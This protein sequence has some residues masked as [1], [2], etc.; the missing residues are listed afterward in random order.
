MSRLSKNIVYNVI[1][2][3]LSLILSFVAVRFIFR[4]LGGDALGLIYFNQS[5]SVAL[6]LALEL[7]IYK[8]TVREVASHYTAN[9]LYIRQLIGTATSFY[10]LA[11]V[12]L[13]T[14]S[15]FAVPA[16]IHHWVHLE[17]LDQITATRVMRILILGTLL[18]LPRG[19]Y[20]SLLLGLERMSYTNILRLGTV[21]VQQFG[22]FLVL[23][24]HGSL[25][26][27][28]Y[29]IVACWL[30]G[31]VTYFVACARL[32]SWRSLLP[33]FS[34]SVVKSNW[35]FSAHAFTISVSGWF[36]G[37]T[38]K[39]VIA[40][41]L[42]LGVMGTYTVAKGAV[43]RCS[44]L[45]VAINEATYPHLSALFKANDLDRFRAQY[46]KLQDLV[47]LAILPIYAAM[48]FVA[49][50]IF[51]FMFTPQV[52]R[53]LLLPVTIL[54]VG[55]YLYGTVT[56]LNVAALAAGK[57]DIMAKLNYFAVF[58]VVLGYIVFIRFFGLAGA[59]L[60]WALY[61]LL[62]FAYSVPRTCRECLG[63]SVGAWFA[64]MVK[65]FGLGGATY[66][67]AWFIVYCRGALTPVWLFSA[68]LLAT[69]AF[70]V[71]AYLIMTEELRESLRR[72]PGMSA[73]SR[74]EANWKIAR[75]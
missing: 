17:T 37:E 34:A 30:L 60:G 27:V 57:P 56:I 8:T 61:P 51:S 4:G 19:L 15:Y 74:V 31:L 5:V 73:L 13:A 3:G 59:G 43:S 28:A 10:W 16:L 70:L 18:N 26:D 67:L 63:V 14:V 25:F 39:F 47:C 71:A 55:S 62:A 11:Y 32:F 24:L 68:Y 29:W 7:G 64:R 21:A 22:I 66:G 38:D 58:I 1:G 2:Q 72:L 42:P 52:G 33:C 45:T 50:P 41:L 12:V 6:M 65:I 23:L 69:L 36:L 53:M 48:P 54:A 75:V 49:P 44:M 35:A 20:D 9:P 40:R 46:Q